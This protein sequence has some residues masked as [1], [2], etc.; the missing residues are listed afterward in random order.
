MTL[1]YIETKTLKD[2]VLA[3]PKEDIRIKLNR[4]LKRRHTKEQEFYAGVM[5]HGKGMPYTSDQWFDFHS[6]IPDK[7]L[8][9]DPDLMNKLSPRQRESLPP[10]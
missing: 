6:K 5:E 9:E 7:L 4:E 1:S 3:R 2:F 10:L 8:R